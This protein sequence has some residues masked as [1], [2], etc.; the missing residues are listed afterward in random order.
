MSPKAAFRQALSAY[1]R[2]AASSEG[3]VNDGLD[4]WDRFGMRLEEENPIG[5]R[6]L[7]V[8]LQAEHAPY[9]HA[10]LDCARVWDYFQARRMGRVPEWR[11]IYLRLARESRLPL[12]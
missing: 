9:P 5:A 3:M 6:L 11:S 4:Y 1:I 8:Y 12:P 10:R 7:D 2:H